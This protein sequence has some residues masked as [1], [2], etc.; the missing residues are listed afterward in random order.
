MESV[1]AR[2]LAVVLIA[3]VLL[4]EVDDAAVPSKSAIRGTTQRSSAKLMT[5]KVPVKAAIKSKAKAARKP[6]IRTSK[7]SAI[8]SRPPSKVA[9]LD[10]KKKKIISRPAYVQKGPCSRFVSDKTQT[11]ATYQVSGRDA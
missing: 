2:F 8:K 7:P 4:I 1:C 5:T 3:S 6:P 10:K 11:C 9:T